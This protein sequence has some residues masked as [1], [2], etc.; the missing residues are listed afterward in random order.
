MELSELQ[1]FLTVASERS[2][3]RAAAKLHR[4]QPA[5]SQ[6]IRRL[7]DE[8]GERLFDRS[9][10]Q[11]ALTEA[12]RVLRE[13]AQRLMRLSARRPRVAVRELR[14]LRRGR[15]LIGA[16]EAAV[17]ALLPLI[18]RFRQAHPEIQ[19]DV[20]RVPSRQVGVEVAQGSLDFGVITFLPAER[21]L[22][23]LSLGPDEL[24]ML[25]HPQHPLAGRK[26]VTLAEFGR[27]A[28]IAH[29]DPSPARERV[30]RTFEQKH[31]PINI[32]VALPS[33]EAIKRAVEMQM[34]V[35]LLPKRCALSEIVARQAGRGEGPAGP[36]GAAAAPGLPPGRGAVTRRPGVSGGG[37]GTAP[38]L[39][40]SGPTLSRRNCSSGATAGAV[41][42]DPELQFRRDTAR[43]RSA[44]RALGEP[45]RV[46]QP[47]GDVRTGRGS[48]A[49]CPCRPTGPTSTRRVPTAA[50]PRRC[51]ATLPPP[52]STRRSTV[53]VVS[54]SCSTAL[55][56][57]STARGGTVRQGSP[58]CTPLPKKIS[59]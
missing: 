8:L 39:S 14:D 29:N 48:G 4:T 22:L 59:E 40:S 42:V 34:G 53:T 35:A 10:K 45:A 47:G 5:V 3:S 32:Q 11:G 9:S 23:T 55:I 12:G 44:L 31:A 51:A 33:L 43:G 26:E 24:V 52:S 36:P 38:R 28:V 37:Q 7:E 30:L 49:A 2:F 6:A 41:G 27:E 20:R 25:V 18:G 50:C 16:N 15:V 17:H 57:C 1:V 21:G 13:Y 46:R 19:V 54:G 56:S 58:S